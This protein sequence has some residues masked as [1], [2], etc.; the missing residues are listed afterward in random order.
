[1][2]IVKLGEIATIKGGK[3]LPKGINLTAEPNQHPY[4]RVR[5]LNNRHTLELNNDFEYVDDK[6]I[7]ND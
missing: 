1:M 4:I 5:D 2:R 7:K 3:R 6:G